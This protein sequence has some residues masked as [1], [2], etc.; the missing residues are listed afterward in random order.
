MTLFFDKLSDGEE[1]REP[2]ATGTKAVKVLEVV[3]E[4]WIVEVVD[5]SKSPGDICVESA[6]SYCQ[7][8]L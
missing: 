7:K 8:T 4:L 3:C 2:R 1:E 5:V 6:V